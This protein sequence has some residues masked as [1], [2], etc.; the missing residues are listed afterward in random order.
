[1]ILN[2]PVSSLGR[3]YF[4]VFMDGV[5]RILLKST[6]KRGGARERGSLQAH[7]EGVPVPFYLGIWHRLLLGKAVA[8]LGGDHIC[9]SEIYDSLSVYTRENAI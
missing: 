3:E 4:Y 1:M 2:I 7:K 9:C 6:L 8:N 5:S